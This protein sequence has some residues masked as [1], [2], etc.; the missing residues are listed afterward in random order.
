MSDAAGVGN[1]NMALGNRSKGAMENPDY[2]K[3]LDRR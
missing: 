2:F 1:E 3:K